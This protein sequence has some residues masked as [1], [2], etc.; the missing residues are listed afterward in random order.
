MALPTDTTPEKARPAPSPKEGVEAV[1]KSAE[2]THAQ[3]EL[4]QE[5]SGTQGEV[6]EVMAGAEKPKEEV[7][8]RQG[9]RGEKRDLSGQGKAQTTTVTVTPPAS[10]DGL[11][12]G[13]AMMIRHIRHEIERQ[14]HEHL[15]RAHHL[16]KN[17]ATGSAQE[18]ADTVFKIRTL[19]E[20]L[21][22][23]FTATFDFIKTLYLRLFTVEG[24]RRGV[25][26]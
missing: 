13:E 15:R 17:L 14:I 18:Y 19:K 12:P 25:Q 3:A 5:F 6:A 26:D 24:K 10:D 23:L 2:K 16:K 8:E 1:L 11:L 22:S 20:T 4:Q 7:S 9:E 21:S